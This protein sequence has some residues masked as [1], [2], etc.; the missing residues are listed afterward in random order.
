MFTGLLQPSVLRRL[1]AT[2]RDHPKT[3]LRTCRPFRFG[4]DAQ[5]IPARSGVGRRRAGAMTGDRRA[6]IP[7]RPLQIP[8]CQACGRSMTLVRS[9]A[10][11]GRLPQLDTW[12]CVD[13]GK[14][15][16]IECRPS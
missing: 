6:E 15:E 1:A 5:P 7:Y 4:V 11:L 13:C 12:R 10:R 14:M 8:Y 2:L 16:T 9:I 3:A